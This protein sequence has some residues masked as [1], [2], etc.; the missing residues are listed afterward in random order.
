[1]AITTSIS[2]TYQGFKGLWFLIDFPSLLHSIQSLLLNQTSAIQEC[3]IITIIK[4]L[5][6]PVLGF[7]FPRY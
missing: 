3:V 5:I 4:V 6:F 2:K 1:M 7:P